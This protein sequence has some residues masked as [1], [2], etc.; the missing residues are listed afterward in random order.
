QGGRVSTYGYDATGQYLTTY[1]DKYGTTHYTYQT[2]QTDLALNNALVQI[3]YSD[4]THIFFGYDSQGRLTDQH[5]DNNQED[6]T[7]AYGAAGGYTVTDADNG[8]ARYLIDD[9]GQLREA[10]NPLGQVTRYTYDPNRQL[11]QVTGP[12]GVSVSYTY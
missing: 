8:A 10:I 5:R 12:L 3:A 9:A 7:Y 1:T 2:G 6:V 4:N 11:T